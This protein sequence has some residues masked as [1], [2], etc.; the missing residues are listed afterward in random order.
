MIPVIM[1][2]VLKVKQKQHRL[3]TNPEYWSD[4]P[5]FDPVEI[6]EFGG[7]AVMIVT[8]KSKNFGKLLQDTT[9]FHKIKV[10]QKIS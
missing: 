5:G 1:A 3:S 6:G 8:K 10:C 7:E 9:S 4:N 2:P